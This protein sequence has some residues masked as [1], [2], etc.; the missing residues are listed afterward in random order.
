MSQLISSAN[1]FFGLFDD[2]CAVFEMERLGVSIELE[3]LDI[4]QQFDFLDVFKQ[5]DQ[6]PY[7]YAYLVAQAAKIF[8]VDDVKKILKSW[9]AEEL[10]AA[11]DIILKLSGMTGSEAESARK[12]SES[13]Q[14]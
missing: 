8:S 12:N 9:E 1:D 3:P 2:A 6:T 4:Q 11:G 14:S 10:Y 7:T 5:H 13:D